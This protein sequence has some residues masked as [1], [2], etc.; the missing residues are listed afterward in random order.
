MNEAKPS[1]TSSVPSV[2]IVDADIR[3][4]QATLAHLKGREQ[5]G[6]IFTAS[7]GYEAIVKLLKESIDV[8]L[9]EVNIETPMSGVF[10]LREIANMNSKAAVIMYTDVLEPNAVFEAFS[11]GVTNFLTK[12]VGAS[13]L[14][15]AIVGAH[16]GR[17]QLSSEVSSLLQTEFKRLR[18]MEDNMGYLLKVML[19]LTPTELDILRLL[20]GGAQ[21]REVSRV[22]FIELTTTKTH[23]S[24]ILR[25]FNMDSMSQVIALLKE[26]NFMNMLE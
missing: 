10:I 21:V 14:V 8:V 12:D 7:S 6:T 19:T 11:H 20:Y 9:M 26:S 17:N 4:Q 5:I 3:A 15:R 25:K 23:I 1:A 22:R 18:A 16:T 24:H 2:L 13:R